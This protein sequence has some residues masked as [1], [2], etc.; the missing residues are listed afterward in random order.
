M[1]KD[2][3]F[4]KIFDE[5]FG[6]KL[7]DIIGEPTESEVEFWRDWNIRAG[8]VDATLKVAQ[9]HHSEVVKELLKER[10]VAWEMLK[11]RLGD[12]WPANGQVVVDPLNKVIREKLR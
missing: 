12:A 9:D 1:T 3:T 10:D 2:E 7:G 11:R 8:A 4:A 5:M 6:Q